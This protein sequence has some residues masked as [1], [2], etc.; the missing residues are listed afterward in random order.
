VEVRQSEAG[1]A[2]TLPEDAG[3]AYAPD[4]VVVLTLGAQRQ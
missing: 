4:R 3:E 1:V 2:L